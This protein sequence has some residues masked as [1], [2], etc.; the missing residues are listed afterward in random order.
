MGV[1]NLPINFKYMD[2]LEY[3]ENNYIT[4]CRN[5]GI[6]LDPKTTSILCAECE[7]ALEEGEYFN[8]D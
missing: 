3:Q 1:L 5:C 7:V 6:E 2:D 4:G 8:E